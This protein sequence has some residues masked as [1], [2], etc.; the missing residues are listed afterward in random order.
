MIK[1]GEIAQCVGLW[2]AEGD[3]KSKSEITLT[4]NYP[5]IIVFFHNVIN[6]LIVSQNLPRVYVYSSSEDQKPCLSIDVEHKYYIDKRANKPYFIYRIADV[7]NVKKWHEIIEKF[8][9]KTEFYSFIL[10]GFFAGEGN[11]KFIKKSR[12]R[13]IRISQGKQNSFLEKVL[14][15]CDIKFK[16]SRKER[17]YVMT[18]R[19]TLERLC[20]LNISSLHGIKKRKLKNMMRTYKQYHYPR[21]FLKKKLYNYLKST[22]TSSQLAEIFK[23]SHARI[24]KILINLKKEGKIKNFR[25]R[26]KSYW[27][28]LDKN[29]IIISKRKQEIL[30]FLI[31]PKYTFEIANHLNVNWKAAYRRLKELEKLKLVKFNDDLWY[32]IKTSKEVKII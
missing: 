31:I 5:K 20:Q 3:N 25:V 23:R 22:Y 11:V 26:S 16:Y 15:Y 2:L 24:T 6:N 1:Q 17:T 10:Q 14:R 30:N 28:R 18:G 9:Q 8:K 12:S 13:I 32:K 27:I 7:Q 4:N 21:D 29:T 19:T